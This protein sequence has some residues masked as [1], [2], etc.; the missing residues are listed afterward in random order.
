I[1]TRAGPMIEYP[2]S[3]RRV[4]GRNLPVT[5]GAYLRIYPYAITRANMRAAEREGV[6]VVFYL[7]PWELD[8]DHPRIVFRRRAWAT[9]YF[10]LRST[11]L[12]LERLLADF[13]FTTLANVLAESYPALRV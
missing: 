6:P 4:W 8:P 12:K 2:I 13:R 3:T 7:H 5:G 11:V 9:H 1:D 10:N